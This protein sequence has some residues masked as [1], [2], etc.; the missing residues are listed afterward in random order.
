MGRGA[1]EQREVL[2]AIV[3]EQQMMNRMPVMLR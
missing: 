2:I 1:L 3:I